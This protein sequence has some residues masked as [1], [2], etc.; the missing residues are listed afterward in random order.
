MNFKAKILSV[1]L[2]LLSLCTQL[3]L[4]A[5]PT[6]DYYDKHVIILVDQTPKT[7]LNLPLAYSDL[8]DL[9]LNN[10]KH[11]INPDRDIIELFA[12]ALPGDISTDHR[13]GTAGKLWRCRDIYTNKELAQ[14][15]CDSITEKEYVYYPNGEQT[16]E[17]F[18]ANMDSVFN[19]KT[20]L[21]KYIQ[22]VGSIG[23]SS[24]S[25]PCVLTK[26]DKN[27]SAKI[28]NIYIISTFQSGYS[29][30]GSFEDYNSLKG[31]FHTHAD[32]VE[33][34]INQI[35][36]NYYEAGI[37]KKT[38]EDNDPKY[39]VVTIG[40]Q[41]GSL[42]AVGTSLQIVNNIS[43][44][45]VH[46]GSDEFIL[47]PLH[48]SMPGGDD[49]TVD[50]IILEVSDKNNNLIASHKIADN[51]K[52][53]LCLSKKP[54]EYI[55]PEQLLSLDR[56]GNDENIDLS[57]TVMAA[58]EPS[59]LADGL[60]FAF[61]E[62]RQFPMSS[63]EYVTAPEKIK[64][65]I[66]I[67]I[68]FILLIVCLIMYIVRSRNGLRRLKDATIKFW[69]I[70]NVNFMEVKNGHIVN[71]PCWYWKKDN[72]QIQRVIN[73]DI[74]PEFDLKLW[75]NKYNLKV[76]YSVEDVDNN[77][78]FSFRPDGRD[79]NGQLLKLNEEYE[80]TP[81]SN[82]NYRIKIL[83]Y[84]DR[85]HA[86]GSE[87]DWTRI[88]NNI[89]SVKVNALIEVEGPFWARKTRYVKTS[90][91]YEFIV[92][93]EIENHD[94]WI[95]LDPG[96][97]GSCM[98][99]GLG[100][101]PASND[102]IFLARDEYA[103]DT[104]GNK[105]HSPIF[106][107]EIRFS[108]ANGVFTDK[109]ID[110][111]EPGTEFSAG[112]DYIFGAAAHMRPG[113]N[114]FQSI[115]KLLG[116]EN[117]QLLRGAGGVTREISGDDLA[118][119]LVKGLCYDFTNFLV[120]TVDTEY[121]IPEYI[122]TKITRNGQFNPSRAIVAVPNN[123]T[124]AKIEAMVRSIRRTGFFKE[125]H[126]I[127]EA[128]GTLMTF[129]RDNWKHMTE[130]TFTSRT[131]VVYDMGGATINATAFTLDV[132][133][134]Q[135]K[136]GNPAPETVNVNTISRIGYTI[137]GDTIDYALIK[138]ILGIPTVRYDLS[139]IDSE[140]E[141]SFMM[142][143]KTGLLKIAREL[144]IAF[145]QNTSIVQSR[146]NFMG[147]LRNALPKELKLTGVE[148]HEFDNDDINY[149]R[150]QN[151][152]EV[153]S[154]I[155]EQ[156]HACVADAIHELCHGLNGTEAVL[157][158]SGRSV[159]YPRIV[160]VVCT[161][162]KSAGFKVLKWNGF[163]GVN[164]NYDSDKVKTAV[165]IGACW[166]GMFS[167]IIKMR[168]DIL[169]STYGYIDLVNGTNK[170]I[171]IVNRNE[172]FPESD[173]DPIEK[174]VTVINNNLTNVQVR[175]M[176]G[177][178]HDEILVKDIRH[179]YNTVAHITGDRIGSTAESIGIAVDRANNITITVTQPGEEPFTVNAKGGDTD[180]TKENSEAYIFAAYS[181]VEDSSVVTEAEHKIIRS[182]HR[183]EHQSQTT[184]FNN[185]YSHTTTKRL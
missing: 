151:S 39:R 45:Q 122:R 79:A 64:N 148:I 72:T 139:L 8:K 19:Q 57:V 95:S 32:A 37:Y 7:T 176:I 161:S 43:L 111:L 1:V 35:S 113:T 47:S 166:Y 58:A 71:L 76:R 171:P 123:Y 92:R 90:R 14:I 105:L 101:T 30:K 54:G 121:N 67:A 159:L 63:A 172:M 28:Y 98:A 149:L 65:M 85:E 49:L 26:I 178:D 126:Y 51:K 103:T 77:D 168:H 50:R 55:I 17:S 23:F 138:M 133:L 18:F 99:V 119:L 24:Y 4:Y 3:S 73:V 9:L 132:V 86:R 25:Y 29:G 13:T 125:I 31:I 173:Y 184:K 170:F 182:G 66:Y 97:S 135:D 69:P 87:P 137:G 124:V 2:T 12:F 185:K 109:P 11:K 154:I 104:Q 146:E 179:K 164:G 41:I 180:I 181:T 89:L 140:T 174:T 143:H 88:D 42:T 46:Y 21:K 20:D 130:P 117:T 106:Y 152:S 15:F 34:Y 162:L 175:Q 84:F 80:V 62:S 75:A 128:E 40:K 141:N 68:A 100:G 112:A 52:E 144:K 78:D 108:N 136:Q 153:G 61:S 33:S 27:T 60:P 165:A 145:I 91:K 83:A 107:S 5:A 81:D 155:A 116:Y 177:V 74:I 160:D 16:I 167:N 10:T 96:T 59:E 129:L 114:H 22:N 134:T 44:K 94:A 115:K 110:M 48:I 127:Y 169:T 183:I 158:C 147:W 38:F 118:F 156:V 36:E 142:S 53:A 120:Q 56:I 82:G 157:I 70:S 150:N 6:R 93:E 131:F 102:N 163:K